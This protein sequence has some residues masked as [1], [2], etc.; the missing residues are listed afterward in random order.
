MFP[1]YV[2]IVEAK[3]KIIKSLRQLFAKAKMVELRGLVEQGRFL[4]SQLR[5]VTVLQETVAS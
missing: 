3:S 5:R 1:V 4:L 2:I